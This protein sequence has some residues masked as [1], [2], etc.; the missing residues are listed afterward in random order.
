VP[1]AK[2]QALAATAEADPLDEPPGTRPGAAGFNGVPSCAFSPRMPSDTSSV[3]VLPTT[4]AP[5]SSRVCTT[6]A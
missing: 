4:E 6:H 2:S 1:S 3:I 5:A